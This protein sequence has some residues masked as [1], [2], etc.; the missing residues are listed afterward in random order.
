MN[1]WSQGE[2]GR[3]RNRFRMSVASRFSKGEEWSMVNCPWNWKIRT[4]LWFKLPLHTSERT[5][6]IICNLVLLCLLAEIQNEDKSTPFSIKIW[7]IS[8]FDKWGPKFQK[9][10]ICFII[11][12]HG[13]LN[14]NTTTSYNFYDQLD[15]FSGVGFSLPLT[16]YKGQHRNTLW[17]NCNNSC[18]WPLG[19]VW[20]NSFSS[21]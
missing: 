18:R 14:L 1:W 12:A 8:E 6:L 4:P 10:S 5:S 9:D 7:T 13:S 15:P 20:S 16:N 2:N 17:N 21:A 11:S 19:E 3:M